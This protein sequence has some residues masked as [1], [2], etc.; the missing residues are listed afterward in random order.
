MAHNMCKTK[1]VGYLLLKPIFSHNTNCFCVDIL[2]LNRTV[3]YTAI[4][5]TVHR[6]GIELYTPLMTF[7]TFSAIQWSSRYMIDSFLQ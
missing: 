1:L 2:W 6:I 3:C 5:L 4:P 7:K